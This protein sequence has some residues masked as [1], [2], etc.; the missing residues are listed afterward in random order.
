MLS[1]RL[2][3]CEFRSSNCIPVRIKLFVLQHVLNLVRFRKLDLCFYFV[4]EVVHVFVLLYQ[5]VPSIPII[6]NTNILLELEIF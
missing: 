1:N 5:T 4:D 3:L 6:R 2:P